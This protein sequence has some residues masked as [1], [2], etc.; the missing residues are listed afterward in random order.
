MPELAC[1]LCRDSASMK[2][3]RTLYGH[4]VCTRCW[5]SF[6][7]R[8]Q[9]AWI[10]DVL[11]IQFGVGFL[12]GFVAAVLRVKFEGV[13]GWLIYAAVCVAV[14]FKD[15]FQG[16]SLGK[17][18]CGV[19]VVDAEHSRP[20]GFGRSFLRNWP[21]AVPLMPLVVAVTMNKGPR[22]GDGMA[23]TRVI[24]KRYRSHP[25]FSPPAAAA[26]VFE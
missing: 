5:S 23:K 8:R 3:P 26:K 9:F 19:Q 2:R 13:S 16:H 6:V 15:G 11:L 17:R 10:I 25:V 14:V 12:V 1:P 7:S 24:W 18:I 4:I 22:I 21:L 20:A